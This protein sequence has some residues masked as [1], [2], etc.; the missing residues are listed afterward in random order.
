MST[1]GPGHVWVDGRL[2][3]AEGPHLSAFDRGFQLG[4]GVFET[5]RA[6][7]GR[8]IEL[9]EH[10][11]R[12]RQSADG[13]SIALPLDIGPRLQAAIDSLLAAEGLD[14]PDGDASVRITVSRGP[15]VQRAL[16]PPEPHIPPTIVVQAWPVV[17]ADPALVARGLHLIASAIRRDVESPLAG[18]KTTSRAEYVYAGQ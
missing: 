12:L 13:L 6:R 7:G 2:L 3:P 10:T 1:P 11:A 15:I 8:A 17:A 5:L 9:A 18:L 4:D 16:L 14:G